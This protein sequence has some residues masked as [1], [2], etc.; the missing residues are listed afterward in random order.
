M[1]PMDLNVGSSQG[2][3]LGGKPNPQWQT[4][5]KVSGD[6]DSFSQVVDGAKS[7]SEKAPVSGVSV[8]E[9][10]AQVTK[11][12]DVKKQT[13][14]RSV[15]MRDLV[16]KLLEAGQA[17]TAITKSLALLMMQYGVELSQDNFEQLFKLLKGRTQKGALESAVFSFSKRLGKF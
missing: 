14:I 3:N 12:E 2:S 11:T 10:S 8:A 17:N 6:S 9:Q 4:D 1:S 7:G 13:E 16:G 5:K 15:E